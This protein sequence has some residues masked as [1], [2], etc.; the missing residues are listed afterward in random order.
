[1]VGTSQAFVIVL[2]FFKVLSLRALSSSAVGFVP[3]LV[4]IFKKKRK[5]KEKE[6]NLGKNDEFQ[7]LG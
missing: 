6:K 7:S 5:K 1:L 3:G 4:G 2:T